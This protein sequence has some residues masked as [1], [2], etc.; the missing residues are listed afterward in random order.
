MSRCLK[1]G[2]ALCRAAG[3]PARS[4]HGESPGATPRALPPC[5]PRPLTQCDDSASNSQ[6]TVRRI[7]GSAP[8]T[9]KA[10]ETK[11]EKEPFPEGYST[12]K[13]NLQ[14]KKSDQ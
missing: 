5:E 12:L 13:E 7:P 4:Y 8:V 1:D 10:R 6:T 14:G 9:G 3:K 2:L 11:T